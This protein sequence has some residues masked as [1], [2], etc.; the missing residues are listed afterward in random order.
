MSESIF[1][2]LG[3]TFLIIS[4]TIIRN[5]RITVFGGVLEINASVSLKTLAHRSKIATLTIKF[6]K[7]FNRICLV[8]PTKLLSTCDNQ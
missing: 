1:I 4:D 8:K 5:Y 2:N 6:R 3:E 7:C